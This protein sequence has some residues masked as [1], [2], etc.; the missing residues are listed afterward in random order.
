M[1]MELMPFGISI[2]RRHVL[3]EG[4]ISQIKGVPWLPL[5]AS[6]FGIGWEESNWD[7]FYSRITDRSNKF[8]LL[9][10]C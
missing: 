3:T 6:P 7:N 4:E 8:N 9:S 10:S 2:Q 5:G 1:R